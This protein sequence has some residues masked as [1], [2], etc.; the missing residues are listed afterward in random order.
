MGAV[1]RAVV[2]CI[3]MFALVACAT[4]STTTSESQSKPRDSRLA[5]LYFIWPK[6]L[7]LKTG[8]LD[9]KVDGQVVGKIAPDSFFFSDH[10]P[11][12]H[13]LKIEPPFDWMY[14]ETDVQIA[15]GGTYYYAVY[16]KPA[17]I[18]GAQ[19]RPTPD[20]GAAME[21]KGSS[22]N[23]A[24]YKLNSLDA[25]TAAHEMAKLKGQ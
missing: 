24:T 17:Y 3:I 20:V 18:G 10:Q 5:R 21:P 7:M 19:L 15:A 13:T 4:V 23:M 8:T 12:T 9:I 25:A 22:F 16:Q 6:S 11:G 1:C 14:F 2:A